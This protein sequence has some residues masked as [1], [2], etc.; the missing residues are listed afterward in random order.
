M[1][2]QNPGPM[3][4]PSENIRPETKTQKK[5]SLETQG[6]SHY[7]ESQNV[8]GVA[9]VPHWGTTPDRAADNSA[10]GS[11]GVEVR[12]FRHALAVGLR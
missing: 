6:R 1:E 7:K 11:V 8:I 12:C 3:A 2:N 10:L 5:K 4:T 9:E